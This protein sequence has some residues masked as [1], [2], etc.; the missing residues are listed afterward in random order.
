MSRTRLAIILLVAS[1][2][3]FLTSLGAGAMAYFSAQ[4]P[5]TTTGQPNTKATPQVPAT[6]PPMTTTLPK[7]NKRYLYVFPGGGMWVYDMDHDHQLVK[8][9]ALPTTNVRGAI[10]SAATG[11]L[12][13]SYGG[14]GG[15]NGNGALLAYDLKTDHIVWT[16]NYNFGVDS[17][18]IS[19]DGKIIYM[20]DGSK[21]YDGNVYLINATDGTVTGT[22]NTVPGAS[23]HNTVVNLQ[24]T[25]IYTGAVNNNNLF[26]F[27][28]ATHKLI[29]KIGPLQ[30]GVRPYAFNRAETLAFTNASF[31]LGFEV[32][33]IMTGKLLY[34]IPVKGFTAPAGNSAPS[35][36]ITLSPDEKEVY[37]IDSPNSYVHV[38]DVSGL[39]AKAPVQ[40]ADIALPSMAGMEP[41]PCSYDCQREGWLEHSRDGRYVYVGDAGVAIDTKTRK[42]AAHIPALVNGRKS[43]EVDWADTTPVFADGRHGLGYAGLPLP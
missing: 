4:S 43:L 31:F 7:A 32:S 40:V 42:I 23:T 9:V 34:H 20:P 25:H 5:T 2:A 38:F 16:K 29:K 19:P 21:S 6:P 35:H 15:S 12:Y 41:P 14:D 17:Q 30:A 18:G 33:D 10:A 3:V 36:G 8:H 1:I 22:M 28:A 39:P 24:G 26:E 37:V 13:L 27:D 11:M